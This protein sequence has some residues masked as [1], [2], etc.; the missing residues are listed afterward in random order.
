[1]GNKYLFANLLLFMS[2]EG[3]KVTPPSFIAEK[4]SIHASNALLE[5]LIAT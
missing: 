5:A 1:M 4:T 2:G 3:D